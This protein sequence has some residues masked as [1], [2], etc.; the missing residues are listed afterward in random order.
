MRGRTGEK[1]RI[2]FH[3][4]HSRG[5]IY[6][7][8][9]TAKTATLFPAKLSEYFLNTINE[10]AIL[11]VDSHV[12]TPEGNVLLFSSPL[13][14]AWS[15]F[16]NVRDVFSQIKRDAGS[17][18]VCLVCDNINHP[19]FPFRTLPDATSVLHFVSN[20]RFLFQE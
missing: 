12:G 13:T 16:L 6:G 4:V 15:F 14:E 2:H 1:Q 7:G 19:D 10:K 17:F 5:D 18:N 8:F 11:P 9:T 20:V 3:D